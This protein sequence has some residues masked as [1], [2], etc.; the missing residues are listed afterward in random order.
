MGWVDELEPRT[1]DI[2]AAAR[3]SAAATGGGP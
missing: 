2:I 1:R 3:D